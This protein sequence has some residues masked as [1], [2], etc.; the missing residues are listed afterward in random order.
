MVM[1]VGPENVPCHGMQGIAQALAQYGK[2]LK[3]L[4]S[5]ALRY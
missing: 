1:A 3:R 2:L 5:V 4:L